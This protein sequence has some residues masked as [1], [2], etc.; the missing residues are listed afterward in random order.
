MKIKKY[1]LFW[2]TG[3]SEIVE[4]VNPA[5]AMNNAGIGSGALGALD[6]YAVGDKRSDYVF[7][8]DKRTW[9]KVNE[10]WEK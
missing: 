8:K 5:N 1:T 4:G 9:E 7:V 3:K 6:F 2:L 10:V